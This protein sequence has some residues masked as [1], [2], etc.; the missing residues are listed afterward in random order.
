MFKSDSFKFVWKDP[1]TFP[2]AN[3][4]AL[5]VIL[6]E[7]MAWVLRDL[8]AWSA[9]SLERVSPETLLKVLEMPHEIINVPVIVR[10]VPKE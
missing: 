10:G 3:N 2:S 1:R 9:S 4:P 6:R 5:D 7:Q 8:R